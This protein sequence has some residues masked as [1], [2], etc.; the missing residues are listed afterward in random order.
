MP[1]YS[2]ASLNIW[3]KDYEREDV[4]AVFD[5]YHWSCEPVVWEDKT[6]AF[7]DYEAEDGEFADVENALIALQV[8]FDR[9]A[10]SF[11]DLS[12]S[13]TQYRPNLPRPV[14]TYT[15][16]DGDPFLSLT[17]LKIILLNAEL[18]DD[19]KLRKIAELVNRED[20]QVLLIGQNRIVTV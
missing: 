9:F 19:A 6:I 4:K 12:A 7:T 5:D 13:V 8:P 1:N 15:A 16:A 17:D 3:I 18:S 20:F 14:T 10:D 11:L 2:R